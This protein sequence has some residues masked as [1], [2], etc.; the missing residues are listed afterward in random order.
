V[1]RIRTNWPPLDER[2][3]T[4]RR[5]L[6]GLARAAVG[7]DDRA[8][9]DGYPADLDRLT[10]AALASPEEAK[11]LLEAAAT[12][13]ALAVGK[14]ALDDTA[15]FVRELDEVDFVTEAAAFE[16][17]V[18]EVLSDPSLQ[19]SSGSPLGGFPG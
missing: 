2:S 4:A 11:R 7:A 3:R 16:S 8:G 6:L 14:M 13:I 1:P 9:G 19:E 17:S 18:D 12:L 10:Q 15:D 5:E